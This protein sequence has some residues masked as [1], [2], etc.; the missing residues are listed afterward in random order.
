MSE[1]T[2]APLGAPPATPPATP[3]ANTPATPPAAPAAAP[4]A[5]PTASPAAP[6]AAQPAANPAQSEDNESGCVPLC[7]IPIVM[8]FL[9]F[10]LGIC[11]LFFMSTGG[12]VLCVI[13][14]ILGPVFAYFTSRVFLKPGRMTAII[15]TCCN[16]LYVI[17]LLST[18]MYAAWLTAQT[19]RS[20]EEKNGAKDK[21]LILPLLEF[22][23]SK[24]GMAKF[25][26]RLDSIDASADFVRL[27]EE[28]SINGNTRNVTQEFPEIS[29]LTSSLFLSTE[30]NLAVWLPGQSNTQ[31]EEHMEGAEDPSTFNKPAGLLLAGQQKAREMMGNQAIFLNPTVLRQGTTFAITNGD[32]AC[33]AKTSDESFAEKVLNRFVSMLD[34]GQFCGYTTY[35]VGVLHTWSLSCATDCHFDKLNFSR[36]RNDA[37]ETVEQE[38]EFM[39]DVIGMSQEDAAACG[40]LASI[41]A[42][43]IQDGSLQEGAVASLAVAMFVCIVLIL[44]SIKNIILCFQVSDK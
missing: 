20:I 40:L 31:S 7:W 37:E 44:F 43:R 11:C 39:K 4:A 38:K 41:T 15:A 27:S 1:P 3:P 32:Y 28:G 35:S 16:V 30:D 18:L 29:P 23:S 5:S 12:L 9:G 19:S 13:N 33:L 22:Y 36:Y 21:Q 6:A 2:G 24:A 34:W 10:G 17:L 8:L 25:S 42:C 14:C 26:R